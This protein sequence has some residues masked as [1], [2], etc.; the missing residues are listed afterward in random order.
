LYNPY[1]FDSYFLINGTRQ[2]NIFDKKFNILDMVSMFGKKKSI[3]PGFGISL[4]YTIFYLSIIVLIP[5]AGLFIKTS[6]L[7]F[8]EFWLAVTEPRVLASYKLSFGASFLAAITNAIF[9]LLIAWVL[10]RYDFFGKKILDALI[11]LPFALPT[12]VAE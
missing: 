1:S 11:D 8:N 5:I 4:G 12:A 3:L 9:G 2:S 6:A 10:V 7:S